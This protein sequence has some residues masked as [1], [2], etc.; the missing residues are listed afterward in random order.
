MPSPLSF[1]SDRDAAFAEC[2]AFMANRIAA[3]R[4]R[5]GRPAL[6]GLCGA[7][8]S[9]KSTTAARL[10]ELLMHAGWRTAVLSLDDFYLTKAERAALARE[11]HPLFATRGVPG[12]H[13]I[14]LATRSIARLLCAGDDETVALPVFDK[15]TDDRVPE[16]N[17]PQHIGRCDIVL[18]EGWCVGARP[19]AD[20][21]LLEPVNA[22]ERTE[23]ADGIWRRHVNAQLG[24]AYRDLFAQLD[25]TFFLR[26][27][28]FAIVSGWRAEQEAGLKHKPGVPPMD[29]HALARFI[30]HYERITRWMLQDEPA[31]FV[32]DLDAG[33]APLRWREGNAG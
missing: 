13:D 30:A 11:V 21:A 8:G 10:A 6:V 15:T 4:E 16:Q 5:L 18:L 29:A 20:P 2:D 19:Q 14:E 1:A 31:D 12:T 27:P 32:I 25:L 17:W 22:L 24:R 26:A 23:D 33:R 7:Q 28:D 9:G 3:S